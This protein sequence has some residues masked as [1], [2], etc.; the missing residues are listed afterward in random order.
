MEGVTKAQ[1]KETKTYTAPDGTEVVSSVKTYPNGQLYYIAN[2]FDGSNPKHPCTCRRQVLHRSSDLGNSYCHWLT[3]NSGADQ[4]LTITFP[5]SRELTWVRVRPKMR[6][7][8]QT[9]YK[10]EVS[11]TLV[12]DNDNL[13][14][15]RIIDGIYLGHVEVDGQ[16]GPEFDGVWQAVRTDP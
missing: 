14:V 13:I 4:T 11:A 2:L 12:D 10:L 1:L 6:T 5:S 15:D 7:D 16:E 8:C 3:Y 9:N